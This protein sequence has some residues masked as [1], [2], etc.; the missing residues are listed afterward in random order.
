MASSGDT[1]KVHDINQHSI[2]VVLVSLEHDLPVDGQPTVL[3]ILQNSTLWSSLL[4]I[5]GAIKPL[6]SKLDLRSFL[7]VQGQ[8]LSQAIGLW[9]D[10]L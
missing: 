10:G 5:R 8:W 2:G 7:F 9:V 6:L 4:E 1:R 3:T